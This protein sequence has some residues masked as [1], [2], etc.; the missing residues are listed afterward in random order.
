MAAQQ[1]TLDDLRRILR[2]VAG[3]T[4]AADLDG[5]IAEQTIGELGYDSLAVL[6]LGARIQQE[7]GTRLGDDAISGESLPRDVL[8]LV[9]DLLASA[10]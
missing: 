3:D 9:N 10:A 6:E 4:E 2:E 5:D 8:A 1:M 7:Y